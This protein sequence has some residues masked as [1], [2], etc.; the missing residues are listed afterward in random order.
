MDPRRLEQRILVVTIDPAWPPVSGADIRNWEIARAARAYGSVTLASLACPRVEVGSVEGIALVH[1]SDR[2]SEEIFRRPPGASLIG[3]SLPPEAPARLEAH[4]AGGPLDVTV[5]ETPALEPLLPLIRKGSRRLVLDLHNIDS[6]L[7]RQLRP[8][9]WW[10]LPPQARRLA[11]TRALERSVVAA[12]DEVWV[13]SAIDGDRLAAIVGFR[14][15]TRVVPN[16]VPGTVPESWKEGRGV[17]TDGP[18]LLFQGHLSYRPNVVAARFLATRILPAVRARLPGARLVLAGRSPHRHVWSLQGEGVDVLADPPDLA[19]ILARADIAVLP[20]RIGSGTRIKALEA[21]AWG[22]PVV[23]TARAV[24]GLEMREE[25][26]FSR[27]ETAAE[28]A[29]AIALLWADPDLYRRRAA[30]GRDLVASR[31]TRARLADAMA[32]AFAAWPES[33]PVAGTAFAQRTARA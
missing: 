20:I 3:L 10:W 1:F 4:L 13:C 27:A 30:A 17:G 15:P 11:R 28:F 12:V 19:P 9:P 22:L 8:R 21:M 32:P 29:A 25:I 18:T 23:G 24:E 2:P 14:P 33:G 26:H 5:I 7:H 6:D 31:Y 16:I